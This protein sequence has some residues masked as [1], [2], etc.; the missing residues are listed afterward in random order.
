LEGKVLKKL[1]LLCNAHLDP[2]WQWEWPEGAAEA[3]STFRVAADFCEEYPGFV[4][5]HNEALLYMWIE[6]YEPELFERIRKLVKQGKWHILG[7]WF[8]QPDCNMP[9]GESFVR[10]LLYGHSYFWKKFGVKSEVAANLDPFGHTR[11]LVQILSKA[12]FKGYLFC[13]PYQEDCPLPNDDFIWVGYD[14]S[15]VIGHRAFGHY[16]SFLGKADEKIKSWLEQNSHRTEG[17]LLWG[18]GNHGGGPSRIDMEKIQA[19]REQEKNF[20]LIHSTAEAYFDELVA[21]GTALPR[22]EKDLNPWAVGCYTS[23]IKIKQKHRQLENELFM[24]EKMASAASLCAGKEYPAQEISEALYDL[25]FAEFHDILPGTVIQPAEEASMRCMD[26]GL[27]ILSRLKTRTFFALAS[28]QPKAKEGEIPILIYNPHPFPITG[29]FACEFMLADQNRKEEFTLPTVYSGDTQLPSQP[30]KEYS[31]IPMDWR[32]RVVF[33]ATLAPSQMNRFDCKLQVIPR[34]P[35]PALAPVDGKLHFKTSELEVVINCET[36][37]MDEY[38]VGG[39]SYLKPNG[40]LPLVMADNDDAWGMLVQSFR[41]KIGSFKLLSP[42]EGTKFSGV[43]ET[44]L[45]SVRVIEDGAVRTVVE[46]VLGY[47]DS[48]ICLTY[49]LPKQGTEVEVQVRVYWMEKSKLLKLSVPTTL[50]QGKYLGQVAYGVEELPADGREA[51]AQK[52]VMVADEN[53][54]L[55]IITDS[56]YGSDFSDGE[57]RL[58]LVRSPGYCGHPFEERTIMPQDR[59][60]P[61]TDQGEHLY[62]FWLNAGA[63]ENRRAVIDREALAHHEKPYALSFF[64]SGLGE[65]PKPLAE[66]TDPVVQLVAFKKAEEGDDYIVRL[67]NPTDAPQE[68]TLKIPVLGVEQELTFGPYEIKT[69]R[70]DKAGNIRE[71]DL[72]ERDLS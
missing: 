3:V 1:H 44:T 33:S 21:N 59:F 69:Y 70:I 58:T 49:R 36:G 23:Q 16:N 9:S 50:T 35:K 56:G 22:H 19:L 66:L 67:F 11:G 61:R 57:V 52:W 65:R 7:G 4:F 53:H 13:R 45:E 38:K 14:G 27:E 37:L 29:T 62:T 24:V 17:L 6:E 15:T 30:E 41:E 51:V 46:A 39:V 25:L 47:G 10:Q 12:G 8:V 63:A 18:V 68:T 26:H 64:P 31:N 48:Y 34:K 42:E 5:N 60:S 32:K 2:V 72:L 20:K 28:G 40:F 55:S 71:Q 43:T 54:A